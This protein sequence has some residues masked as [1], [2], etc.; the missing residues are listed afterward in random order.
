MTDY[1]KPWIYVA[2]PYSDG[3]T[4]AHVQAAVSAADT[5]L[6]MELFPYI[7]HLSHLWHLISPKPYE[8]WLEI[9]LHALTKCDALLRLPGK[10]SGARAEVIFAHERGIHVCYSVGEINSL[11]L[12]GALK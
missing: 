2:G 3:D 5:L 9:D 12:S 6:K 7:P 1:N 11:L 10:S 8:E 4:V